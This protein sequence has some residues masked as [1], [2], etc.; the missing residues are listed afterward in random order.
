MYPSRGRYCAEA[1]ASVTIRLNQAVRHSIET[2]QTPNAFHLA[3][4]NVGTGSCQPQLRQDGFRLPFPPEDRH[5]RVFSVALLD[6]S[7]N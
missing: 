6:A 4:W 1:H 7:M 2:K 3:T 5:S